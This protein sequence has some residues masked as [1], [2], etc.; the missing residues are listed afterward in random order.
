MMSIPSASGERSKRKEEKEGLAKNK[1]REKGR[2]RIGK[3]EKE[4]RT[5]ICLE[6]LLNLQRSDH[7]HL[8][9]LA[10]IRISNLLA[11]DLDL[12]LDFSNILVQRRREHPVSAENDETK[13]QVPSV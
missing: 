1:R 2:E 3:R 7:K 4:E 10:E 8:D 13:S 9:L 12:F 5:S 6:D 11:D